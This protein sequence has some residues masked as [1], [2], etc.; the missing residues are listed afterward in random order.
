[1]QS[2]TAVYK[3]GSACFHSFL[4]LSD[5]VIVLKQQVQYNNHSEHRTMWLKP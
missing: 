2:V 1:M 5:H 4:G 3:P